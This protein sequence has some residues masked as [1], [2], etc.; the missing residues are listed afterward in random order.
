[1]RS[2]RSVVVSTSG[3]VTVPTEIRE[4]LGIAPGDRVR[5]FV[6]GDDVSIV[7]QLSI[8][9]VAGSVKPRRKD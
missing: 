9:D 4:L 7:R 1:M 2:V 5:F 3:Q 8:A 6:Q